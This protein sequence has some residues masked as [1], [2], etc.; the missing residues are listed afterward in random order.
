MKTLWILAA[1]ATF[2]ACANRGEEDV[3]AAPD[4]GDTTAV[5]TQVDT[6]TGTWD[7]TSTTGD[8]NTQPSDTGWTET[9]PSDTAWTETTP[10]DTGAGQYPAPSDMDTSGMDSGMGTDTTSTYPD[11][12]AY[13]PDTSAAGVDTTY[14]GGYDPSAGADTSTDTSGMD[15]GM[16]TDTTSTTQPSVP[17][18]PGHTTDSTYHDAQ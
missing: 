8:V 2:T 17:A 10:S 7:T 16:G 12:G 3:G 15:S 1:A 4:R 13:V 5:T 18:D 9:A 6:A 11:D 14:T